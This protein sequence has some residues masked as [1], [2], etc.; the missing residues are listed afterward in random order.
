[1]LVLHSQ[2]EILVCPENKPLEFGLRISSDQK[3][4]FIDSDAEAFLL[5]ETGGHYKLSNKNNSQAP[6]GSVRDKIGYYL[7]SL[8]RCCNAHRYQDII[9]LSY[10]SLNHSKK[11]LV[12]LGDS[13]SMLFDTLSYPLDTMC[14]FGLSYYVNEKFVGRKIKNR[15]D[16]LIFSKKYIYQ[17]KNKDLN[18]IVH[19]DPLIA[20]KM[21]LAYIIIE[22]KKKKKK[23]KSVNLHLDLDLHFIEPKTLIP[24]FELYKNF[25]LEQELSL[26]YLEGRYYDFFECVYAYTDFRVLE[27]WLIQ[28]GFLEK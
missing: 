9:E 5:S 1:M 16:T 21:R 18:E 23:I 19:V 3:I 27:K 13:L 8:D 10:F 20:N 28:E 4:K 2:G 11:K 7:A 14:F 17:Y 26:E 25:Y 6:I 22:Q 15:G 24:T 12:V